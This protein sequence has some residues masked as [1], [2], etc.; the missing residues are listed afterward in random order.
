MGVARAQMVQEVQVQTM[1]KVAPAYLVPFSFTPA[2]LDAAS[3]CYGYYSAPMTGLV[4]PA[5]R[6]I[7]TDHI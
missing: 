2:I 5:R 6:S 4:Q 3:P 7:S 1:M